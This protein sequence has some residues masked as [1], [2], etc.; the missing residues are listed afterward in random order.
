MTPLHHACR[1]GHEEIVKLIT[2]KVNCWDLGLISDSNGYTPLHFAAEYG[3]F[4]CVKT[5]VERWGRGPWIDIK[6]TMGSRLN[7]WTKK[8]L[9]IRKETAL[10][11]ARKEKH[12]DIV[13]F[14]DHCYHN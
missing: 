14:L 6:T 13:Q 11:L 3:N 10:H 1:N 2:A 9:L 8:D 12:W 4:K 5:L 7:G